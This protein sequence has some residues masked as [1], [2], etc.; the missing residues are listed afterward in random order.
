M[1]R[2]SMTF[3]TRSDRDGAARAPQ[4]ENDRPVTRRRLGA[5]DF[6]APA[7]LFVREA[8]RLRYR[9]F[10]R[11]AL[12]V[13]FAKEE[14]VPRQFLSCAMEVGDSRF[15]ADDIQRLYESADYPLPRRPDA[16]EDTVPDA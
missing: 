6:E 9:G 12:A 5:C 1:I 4:Q 2:T 13:R 3:N 8:S 15:T 14:L 11:A 16:D 7:G 10:E